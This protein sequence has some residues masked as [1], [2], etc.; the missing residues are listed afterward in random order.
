MLGKF[1][2][3]ALVLSA[4]IG[5]LFST[6]IF[7]SDFPG[8]L[9]SIECKGKNIKLTKN[10]LAFFIPTGCQL[11]Y[12][13]YDKPGGTSVAVGSVAVSKSSQNRGISVNYEIPDINTLAGKKVSDSGEVA[14]EA[15]FIDSSTENFA[16]N[17]SSFTSNAKK[18][19]VV[20]DSA[21]FQQTSNNSKSNL[22]D[23]SSWV[24]INSLTD[25]SATQLDY[26]PEGRIYLRQDDFLR[27]RDILASFQYQAA[28]L[29]ASNVSTLTSDKTS[30]DKIRANTKKVMDEAAA[31][32]KSAPTFTDTTATEPSLPDNKS[33]ANFMGDRDRD[34][35]RKK[36]DVPETFGRKTLIAGTAVAG[37]VWGL[38]SIPADW[39]KAVWQGKTIE[40]GNSLKG[41]AVDC[42]VNA[43]VAGTGAIGVTQDSVANILGRAWNGVTGRTGDVNLAG[44]IPM[45]PVVGVAV[46]PR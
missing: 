36:R 7:A 9:D 40:W 8:K 12:S 22:K 29:I 4:V 24:M 21:I 1:E 43:V 11:T 34:S 26:R 19:Y 28:Q 14:I 46:R 30:Q 42:V 31:Y 27:M 44:N 41:A 18:Q 37:C 17:D 38:K 3:N 5:C 16:D 32:F 20:M 2:K 39:L 35:L 6:E 13:I 10:T 15:K 23:D 25:L 33:K 45:E